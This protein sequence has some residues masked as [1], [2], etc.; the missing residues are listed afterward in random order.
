MCLLHSKRA[1]RTVCEAAR[2]PQVSTV[3]SFRKG[4]RDRLPTHGRL[5]VLTF[6]L[7]FSANVISLCLGYSLSKTRPILGV[8]IV[9]LNML[10]PI[11][12]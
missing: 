6:Y 10:T 3:Q 2:L 8:L 7:Q 4:F 5:G 9:R 11:N 1:V 12:P